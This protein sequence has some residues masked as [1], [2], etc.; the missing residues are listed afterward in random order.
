[1]VK[2]RT[3]VGMV[4]FP[5]VLLA[6]TVRAEPGQAESG[7]TVVPGGTALAAA[8]AVMSQVPNHVVSFDLL[9]ESEMAA[10]TA[11]TNRF[12]TAGKK[13]Q[14]SKALDEVL[15]PF[16]LR[17]FEDG[18]LV[19]IG[20]GARVDALYA[21]QETE[22]LTANQ[23]RI[24]PDFSGGTDIYMALRTIQMLAGINMNFDYM[25]PEHRG[26]VQA[27]VLSPANRPQ[28][29]EAQ[30]GGIKTTYA[31]PAGQKCVWRGVLKE[32]LD[33]IGYT[34]VEENGTVKPM[35]VEQL[36]KFTQANIN[37]KPLV[38]RIVKINYA[39]AETIVEKVK[40]MNLLKHE[41]GFMDISY[42]KDDN[43]KIYQGSS[44][45]TMQSGS[46]GQ[47]MGAQMT[48]DNAAFKQ[49][50]RPR[51]PQGIILADVE[52]NLSAIEKQIKLLDTRERQVLIEALILSLSDEMKKEMGVKWGDLKLGYNS[53]VSADID[54]SSTA[55][56]PY[57][58]LNADGSVVLRK[59]TDGSIMYDTVG[60]PLVDYVWKVPESVN[61]SD[62]SAGMAKNHFA[63][64]P[65]SFDAVIK[66]IQGD[67]YSK[68]LGNP[69]IT[70]GDRGEAIIQIASIIPI[71]QKKI[72]YN[73]QANTGNGLIGNSVEWLSLQTGTTLW[74]SPEISE[75]GDVVRLS[76]HP[77]IVTPGAPIVST[78]G[79]VN[80]QLSSQE[81]DTRVSVRSGETLLLGGLMESKQVDTVSKVPL[82]GD[83]PL[84]GRLFSYKGKETRQ[85]HL[86]LLIRPTVLDDDKP[87]TGFE[88][89]S[90]K[91][92]EPLLKGIG[93]TLV[94]N[95]GEDPVVAKE[96]ALL[97]KMG[98][99]KKDEPASDEKLLD[100]LNHGSTEAGATAK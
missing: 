52:E 69:V 66:M 42:A 80:Y 23:T 36:A 84:L 76:V 16:Q 43:A 54:G 3:L 73:A 68:N 56:T 89:P 86:V 47:K 18:A 26:V 90:L 88:A 94:P 75:D 38:T 81:L 12:G 78:D 4:L 55:L 28:V 11:A 48:G 27:A 71:E 79:Q 39:N 2:K 49:L 64:A 21:A 37:A 19:K 77:Q 24:D 10:L 9:A 6:Q 93:K 40:K 46:S 32:V 91:I 70:V 99:S 60:K 22:R 85:S 13:I 50:S 65:I 1:M 41:K 58:K 61:L 53:Q 97:Q 100:V 7:V 31:V 15:R 57:P 25:K 82:L 92:T 17:Y 67:T 34:F 51:T 83:I 30:S 62:W 14:W 45:G 95:K 5:V 74:V 63:A 59:D 35:P 87:N 8:H 96:K 20:A 44:A 33:P 72:S 98:L 29:S